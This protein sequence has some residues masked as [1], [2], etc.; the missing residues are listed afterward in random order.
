MYI[1]TKWNVKQHLFYSI[2]ARISTDSIEGLKYYCSARFWEIKVYYLC[3]VTAARNGTNSIPNTQE[4][5]LNREQKHFI[6]FRAMGSIELCLLLLSLGRFSIKLDLNVILSTL[7]SCL[8]LNL[9]VPSWLHKTH[10]PQHDTSGFSK[11]VLSAS[12]PSVG[13]GL[14]LLILLPSTHTQ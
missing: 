4:S 8:K 5:Q 6:F 11:P 13:S 9:K 10:S 12:F 3:V 14:L 7:V 1:K 2:E